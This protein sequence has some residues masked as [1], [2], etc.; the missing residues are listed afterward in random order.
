MKKLGLALILILF[1]G[2][3][4]VNALV[5][6]SV[7]PKPLLQ[8][9]DKGDYYQA[10]NTEFYKD[11]QG[12][13]RLLKPDESVFVYSQRYRVERLEGKNWKTVGIPTSVTASDTEITRHY[14]DYLGATFDVIYHIDLGKTDV[15]IDSSISA[16]YRIVW[17]LDGITNTEYQVNPRGI[18]F[19]SSVDWVYADWSMAQAESF[20]SV[21]DTANGKKLDVIFDVGVI[22]AGES[23]LLDPT[24]MDSYTTANQDT[25]YSMK[26]LHPSNSA[27]KSSVGQSFTSTGRWNITSVKFYLQETLTA[28]GDAYAH[29][30]AHSGV[31]GASSKPT[32]APLAV[33]E[34]VAVSGIGAGLSLIEFTFN[35]SNQYQLDPTQTYCIAYINPT[36]GDI[37]GTDYITA[38]IDQSAPTHGGNI[39]YYAN[40]AWSFTAGYDMIFY[41]YVDST[42]INEACDSS[43]TIGSI[44]GWVNITV[45]DVDGVANLKTVDIQVNTTGDAENFTLR[46][47]QAGDSFSELSDP[48]DIANLQTGSVR[49]NINATHD[50]ISFYFNITGG[51]S[52]LCD[53]N[54]TTEDDN[55]N[56]AT[57][58]NLYLNEFTY[59][60]YNWGPVGDIIDSAFSFWN[61][62]GAM[63]QLQTFVTGA[64]SRFS[65]SLTDLLSLITQQFVII[66]NVS[67]WFIRWFTR[68]ASFFVTLGG[69]LVSL[70]NGTHA[71]MAGLTSF[72]DTIGFNASTF[73]AV[74]IFAFI[75]WWDSVERRGK[76]QGDLQVM[77]GD[78]QTLMNIVGYFSGMFFTVINIVVDYTFRLIEAI[79]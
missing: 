17:E 77:L 25:G 36:A 29:L 71:I 12:Y 39:F 19:T 69:T 4:P 46:W 6:D 32:G 78:A 66:T 45:G 60:Y 23:Y 14:T 5:L 21:S 9:Y 52:G 8:V 37:T 48:D 27:D 13:D 10:G 70:F 42:P 3:L 31:Y 40:S 7:E 28:T 22:G 54:V 30:Y 47:T 53:V 11:S 56:I 73:T 16:Q 38:G 2:I 50:L 65:T 26:D 44:P 34:A 72:W 61:V 43:T 62:T 1:M 64:S 58:Y 51:T 67:T 18:N 55:G 76:T 24:L 79:T 20:F 74:P 75:W 15:L 57:I 35:A 63:T 59:T 41:L 33:S 49:I 68:F